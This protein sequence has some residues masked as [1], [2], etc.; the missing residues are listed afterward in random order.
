MQ[1][2]GGVLS[3]AQGPETR[4]IE[5][6]FGGRLGSG[7]H[8]ELDLDAIDRM[9]LAGI[10]DVDS[11]NN[12]GDLARRRV[13]PQPAAHLAARPAFEQGAVHVGSPAGHR[14]TRI[15]VFLHGMSDEALWRQDGH[16]ASVD[17]GLGCHP[18]YA[19]EM[20]D[21][22]VGVD[23]GADRTIAA[24]LS[25][26]GQRCG[27]GLRRN[28]GVYDDD[29][30]IAFNEGDV[31]QVHSPNLIDALDDRVETLFGGQLRLAP[32]TGMYR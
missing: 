1:V 28:Q 8:L 19:P 12:H 25:V 9:H 6:H 5:V 11:R 21:M 14:G 29:A 16:S 18:Q 3:H 32:Q 24:V 2:V 26:Q 27:S 10:D 13:L 7:C 22:A 4:E 20:I 15:N 30:G 31:G 23:H 17:V